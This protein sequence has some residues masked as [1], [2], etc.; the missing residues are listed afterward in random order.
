[1]LNGVAMVE[2][3]D[4]TEGGVVREDCV[5]WVAITMAR[6]IIMAKNS[7]TTEEIRTAWLK[8]KTIQKQDKLKCE[9]RM[10]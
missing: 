6:E 9:P 7:A 1:M 3:E 10:K 2:D 5:W 8:S 4:V